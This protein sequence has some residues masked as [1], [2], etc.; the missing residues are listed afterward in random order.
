MYERCDVDLAGRPH[1]LQS[2]AHNVKA[3][4]SWFKIAYT[5]N[6]GMRKQV[7]QVTGIIT[8]YAE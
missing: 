4:L 3:C 7:W 6:L 2:G 1:E 8:N 5:T